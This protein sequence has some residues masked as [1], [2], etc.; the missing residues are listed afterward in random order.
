MARGEYIMYLDPDDEMLPNCVSEALACAE[1][2][3]ADVVDFQAWEKPMD[4]EMR[5]W[6]CGNTTTWYP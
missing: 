5:P 4:G 2:T 3:G 6:W 1:E